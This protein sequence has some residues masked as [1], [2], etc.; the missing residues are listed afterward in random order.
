[1][2]LGDYLSKKTSANY[3][4]VDKF[5]GKKA[6]SL[7]IPRKIDA[8]QIACNFYCK[9]CDNV[10]TFL[11]PSDIQMIQITESLISIDARLACSACK[12]NSIPA[13]FL[14]DIEGDLMS[15]VPKVRLVQKKVQ[16]T[17]LVRPNNEKYGEYAELLEKAH[18]AFEERLG[19]GSIVYLRKIFEIITYKVAD[20]NSINIRNNN[21]NIFNFKEVL[22]RVCAGRKDFI[23]QE[24]SED[25]YKLFRELSNVIHGDFDENEG[26]DK[27]PALLRLVQGILDNHV[28]S[29]EIAD[30]KARLWGE[31]PN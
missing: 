22:M 18:R 31:Q 4:Q 11:S 3:V 21:N 15:Q 16:Y 1:M 5:L 27:Y 19:A 2:R 30:A 13:W 24:F 17:N 10:R 7:G 26:I 20:A 23:P 8:G 28:K 14:V 25:G 6:P 9:R 12:T 29:A